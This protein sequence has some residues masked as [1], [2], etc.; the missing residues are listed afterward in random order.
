MVIQKAFERLTDWFSRHDSELA[1]CAGKW[2]AI[3]DNRLLMCGELTDVVK[4]AKKIGGKN[5]L[6]GKVPAPDEKIL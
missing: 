2:V 6:I 3:A 4:T 1:K 5:V